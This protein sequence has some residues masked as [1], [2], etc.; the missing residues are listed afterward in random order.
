MI[1][2][3]PQIAK[4][5]DAP[6]PVLREDLQ[7]MRVGASYSGAPTWVVFD[8]IR[9]RFF[10]ITYEMFQLLSLW[11][12]SRTVGNLLRTV[13]ARLV[14][15]LSVDDLGTVVRMLEHNLLL[16]EPTRGAWRALHQKAQPRHAWFMRL[17][18][19]YLFFK[20]PLVRPEPFIRATWPYVAFLFSRVFWWL[21][22]I[23]GL[24]GVYL[25]SRQWDSFI[26]TFPFVFSLEGAAISI[27]SVIFIKC[28]HE[29]GHAYVAHRF[30]CRIPTMGVAFMVMMPLLY[31]DVSDA[32]K[33][34]SR[35]QRLRIDSA[36]MLV[37]LTVAAY[38]LLAWAFVPDGPLRS[39]IFVLAATG[40]VLSLL[41]NLNPFMRF[42]GYYILADMLGVEN[43]Q[44]RSF[45]HM[46]WRLREF[47]FKPGYAA[48]EAFPPRLDVILTAYAIATAIYRL[49]L[50]LGIA[51]LVYHFTIKL[52]GILLFVVEIGFFII[53]PV[54]MEVK[55][56]WAMRSDIVRT[57]RTYVTLSILG[58]L[59]VLAFLPLSTRVTAPAVIYPEQ[60][61][62][63]YPQEP[64][65]VEKLDISSGQAVKAGDIL[66]VIDAPQIREELRIANVEIEL[67]RS[68]L[69]RVGANADDLAQRSIIESEL[70]SS[71]AR[72]TGLEERKASLIVR[73]P[74]EGTITEINPE[75]LVG[76]W[77]GRNEQI[78]ILSA[79]NGSVA[80]GYVAGNDSSRLSVNAAGWFIPDDLSQPRLPV[81]LAAIAEAGAREIDLPQLS[82]Q[83]HGAI[84]VHVAT[85]DKRQR[86]V[87]ISAQYAVVARIG[88]VAF[89]PGRSVQGVMLLDG[90]GV[91]FAERAWRRVLMV[92]FREAGF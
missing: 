66:F 83:H 48:P 73:A 89:L 71:L 52:V 59:L 13:N 86:L 63:L 32:W 53:R 42:D 3:Q 37:E 58:L 91:S 64:G 82:S 54:V 51:V 47:L 80:R 92:L 77:V 14:E 43:L 4:P 23:V 33:L 22:A 69:A 79:G 56:W 15:R 49:V 7:I 57:R 10:R 85:E 34:K 31:T 8:P 40:V 44:P 67:A 20:I 68:R 30:G 72:K 74:F 70:G 12:V 50:Y 81:T 27:L 60:F 35:W 61:V 62:R 76:Q 11:N 19:N 45:R 39:A 87:P 1:V 18:H 5:Q 75:I 9:N 84:A 24:I 2:G 90:T 78:A 26:G 16:V 36:G 65:R 6:L 38:A 55:E 28:L 88:D 46:R 17:I 25:V 21:S 29:L 41:V